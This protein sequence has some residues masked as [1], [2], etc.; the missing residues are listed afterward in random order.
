MEINNIDL[1]KLCH[2]FQVLL[3]K[4][5][6]LYKLCEMNIDDYDK[7]IILK[8]IVLRN[9]IND[10]VRKLH[11]ADK[12]KRVDSYAGENK[13]SQ[14]STKAMIGEYMFSKFLLCIYKNNMKLGY[15]INCPAIAEMIL[16]K[17]KQDIVIEKDNKEYYFNVDVK[18]QFRNNKFNFLT[19]NIESFERMKKK[20]DFFIG[21]VIDG[22][23]E[24]IDSNNKISFYF[25]SMDYFE[26]ESIK[27]LTSE[28]KNFS[29]YRKLPLFSLK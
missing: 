20:G 18:S 6:G 11:I 21:A 25:I 4:N 5:I 3:D 29:P 13:E 8:S 14:I 27:V 26:K 23:Q 2:G 19:V 7:D 22:N 1:N 24:N 17:K 16:N 10:N 9:L 28:Y 12:F 15:S